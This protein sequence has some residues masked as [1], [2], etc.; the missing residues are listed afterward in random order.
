MYVHKKPARL[1]NCVPREFVRRIHVPAR[2]GANKIA[3]DRRAAFF[4]FLFLVKFFLLPRLP[5]IFINC[6][7][8]TPG[9]SDT[10][11]T[12]ESDIVDT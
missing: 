8:D 2:F 9:Q 6:K 10:N 12:A 1:I 7:K 4:V 3:P 5:S 11:H